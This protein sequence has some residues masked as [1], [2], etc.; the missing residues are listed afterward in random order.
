MRVTTPKSR[1]VLKVCIRTLTRRCGPGF[2]PNSSMSTMCDSH[3][4]GCQYPAWIIVKARTTPD[5][6]R[7]SA[8][9]GLSRTYRGSSKFT[10]SCH[11]TG[12][13]TRIVRMTRIG[14]GLTL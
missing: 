11:Q 5:H 9:I 12:A 4:S 6:V 13:N 7:P 10:K 8:T 3:V 2:S 1:S 14:T